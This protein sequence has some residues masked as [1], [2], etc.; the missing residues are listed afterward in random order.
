MEEEDSRALK[1][2]SET[3]KEK[4]AKKQNL[5]EEVAEL[6]RHLQIVPNDEDNVCTEATPLARKVPVV[7]YEN[8]NREDLEVLCELVKERFASS[9]PKN[10]SNDFLLTTLTYMF[11]KPDVQAQVRKNQRTVHGLAKFK[12]WRLLESCGVH[13]ITFTSTQMI[14]LV[15]RRYPLSRFTLDQLINNVRL[16]V[17]EESEKLNTTQ[18]QQKALDDALVTP[19]N[20]LEFKKCNMRLKTD[21][22]PKEATFQVMLDALALTPFYQAFLITADIFP[23]ILGQEFE[24]LHLEQDILSFIRDI[25]HIGDITYL[26]N[27]NVDYLYRP[28]R[29]FSI[30]I[31]KC[32]SGKETR[33]DKNR[34]SRAQILWVQATKGNKIKTKAKVA[35][36]DKKQPPKKPKAKGLAMLSE[37]KVLDEQ[38]KKTYGINEGTEFDSDEIPDPYKSNDEHDKEKEEYDDE[39]NVEEG[40]K[41]DEEKDDEVSKEFYK[42][43]GFEQEEEDAHV[44]LKPVLDT[45]KTGGPRQS[46]SISSDFTSK[47]LKLDN[48]FP[49]DTTI[50]SLMDTTVH[51][52]IT[53]TTTIPPPPL[54]FNPLQQEATLTS[55]PTTSKTTTSLPA[56]LVFASVFRFNE[57]TRSSSQPQSSYEASA[58]LSVFELTKILIDKMEKNKSFDVADYKREL[59]NALVKSYNTNK[60][61]LKIMKK[62][63]YAHLEEIEVRRADQRLYTFKEGYRQAALS[64][65]VDTKSKEVRWWKGIR[66]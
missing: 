7:D 21:I 16:E 46:S 51:H 59:Y 50:A 40:E 25:G 28:W 23:K 63:D 24:D 39:F 18:A 47:L 43:S 11:E 52:E 17:E 56:L 27:V 6:K 2:L 42:D 34:L 55:I 41:M 32:L 9:K 37:S 61:I 22:K 54:F 45:Q 3:Q 57:R 31:N 5:D 1:R 44:T 33:I 60:V 30:V 26:T 35:K 20:C 15:E 38:Q 49:I 36:S 10:F 64:K 13:I 14:L 58:T 4:A 62:Y 48:P 66:E 12:S 29:A 8:F 65:E 19:A 53:S